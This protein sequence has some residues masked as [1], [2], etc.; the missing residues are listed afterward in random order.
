MVLSKILSVM[1]YLGGI[2]A[3]Y[4][5]VDTAAWLS[6][7]GEPMFKKVEIIDDISPFDIPE[8]SESRFGNYP[9]YQKKETYDLYLTTAGFRE[10]N[11]KRENHIITYY[12]CTDDGTCSTVIP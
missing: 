12:G 2:Y 9:E 11:E 3:V 4:F 5:C 6:V 1:Y 8:Y 10:Y 7:Y